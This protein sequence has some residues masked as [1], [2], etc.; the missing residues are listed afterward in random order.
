MVTPTHL[1]SVSHAYSHIEGTCVPVLGCSI[2]SCNFVF[3]TNKQIPTLLGVSWA[4]EQ[5]A[6][7]WG[8]QLGAGAALL[9]VCR[10][11]SKDWR[12]QW[13]CA[14]PLL[15]YSCAHQSCCCYCRYRSLL[16]SPVDM[17]RRQGAHHST[18]THM[19][20]DENIWG[21]YPTD[22][23]RHRKHGKIYCISNCKWH[24][25]MLHAM[26]HSMQH[27]FFFFF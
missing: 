26:L 27:V 5:S 6:E 2:N 22:M 17:G 24:I 25:N 20:W 19:E 8:W 18:Q 7:R 12:S 3:L 15:N 11:A 16:V 9:L 21:K 13:K 10:P 1:W 4:L 23:E 14:V